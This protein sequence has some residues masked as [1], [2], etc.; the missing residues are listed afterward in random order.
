MFCFG[1]VKLPNCCLGVEAG[2][3]E[4]LSPL[5]PPNNAFCLGDLLDRLLS[6]GIVRERKLEHYTIKLLVYS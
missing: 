4:L 6:I 3:I 1:L 2:G 5:P